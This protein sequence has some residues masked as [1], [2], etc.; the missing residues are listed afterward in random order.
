MA[1][2]DRTHRAGH[3]RRVD[4]RPA[5][6]RRLADLLA[7]ADR[8]L[9]ALYQ[10]G[11][12][13]GGA[14]TTTVRNLAEDA[15]LAADAIERPPEPIRARGRMRGD[16]VRGARPQHTVFDEAAFLSPEDLD[17]F[18][19]NFDAVLRDAMRRGRRTE[20]FWTPLGERPIVP[21]D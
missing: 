16:G 8:E 17:R 19:V 2:L 18:E 1:E 20:T 5:R 9:T 4:D 13:V 3:V 14:A 21:P 15:A 6:L 12:R 10:A 7:E 11:V